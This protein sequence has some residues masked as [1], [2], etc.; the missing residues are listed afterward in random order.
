MLGCFFHLS[1]EK[2]PN[3]GG[4]VTMKNLAVI[5]VALFLVAT[6]VSASQEAGSCGVSQRANASGRE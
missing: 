3:L 5:A 4:D 2:R 6:G 1:E